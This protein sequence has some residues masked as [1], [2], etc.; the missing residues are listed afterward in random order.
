MGNIVDIM[1]TA[2][3]I[4]YVLD[5][6]LGTPIYVWVWKLIGDPRLEQHE[7]RFILK[8]GDELYSVADLCR[9][10]AYVFIYRNLIQ[11]GGKKVVDAIW[12]YEV[13]YAYKGFHHIL[14]VFIQHEFFTRQ[15]QSVSMGKHQREERV[16]RVLS[17]R[18]HQQ[19]G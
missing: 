1:K 15:V 17:S 10:F 4:E 5:D 8:L 3:H 11:F 7:L 12:L 9:P 13:L 14:D 2:T 16:Y 19:I 6:G 18:Q